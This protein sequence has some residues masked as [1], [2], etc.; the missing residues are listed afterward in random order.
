M[1]ARRGITR[2]WE[3]ARV[4]SDECLLS[5]RRV[6]DGSPNNN[7][8]TTHIQVTYNALHQAHKYVPINYAKNLLQSWLAIARNLTVVKISLYIHDDMDCWR[9]RKSFIESVAEVFTSA[10]SFSK[11]YKSGIYPPLPL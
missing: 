11:V 3:S 1:A 8:N 10:L 5:V 2:V 6:C 4:R 9:T 7:R